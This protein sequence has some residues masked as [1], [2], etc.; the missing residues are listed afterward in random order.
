MVRL[1]NW[2][3]MANCRRQISLYGDAAETLSPGDFRFQAYALVLVGLYTLS[4]T[5]YRSAGA[6]WRKRWDLA[7]QALVA[8]S[9]PLMGFLILQ[10]GL[11]WAI[12]HEDPDVTRRSLGIGTAALILTAITLV[13]GVRAHYR[14][15]RDKLM[16][17]RL[18]AL[19]DTVLHWR[20]DERESVHKLTWR[21]IQLSKD[22]Q[23]L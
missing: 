23:R 15:Y 6:R 1:W 22:I 10:L 3:S 8:L 9:T 20:S 11:Y 16:Q 19:E 13:A 2:H 18:D 21:V 17:N 4:F 14:W 5:A 12:G 7:L